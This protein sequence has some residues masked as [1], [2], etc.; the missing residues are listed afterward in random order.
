MRLGVILILM[1]F[2][3]QSF[4]VRAGRK[5]RLTRDGLDSY[6]YQQKIREKVYLVFRILLKNLQM[7]KSSGFRQMPLENKRLFKYV[8]ESV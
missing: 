3:G 1:V 5:V 7:E 8:Y 4:A 2:V 6:D